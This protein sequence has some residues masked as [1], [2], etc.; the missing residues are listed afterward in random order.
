MRTRTILAAVAVLAVGGQLGWLAASGRLVL[1]Q[2][3]GDASRTA[4]G[5]QLPK[6]DP[7]FRAKSGKRSG[8]RRRVT[9]SR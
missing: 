9:P 4:D 5:S 7:V 3:K 2:D 1:A 8:T 6:P